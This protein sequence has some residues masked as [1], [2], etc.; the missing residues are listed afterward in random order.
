MYLLISKKLEDFD[1]DCKRFKELLLR[2]RD[3]DDNGY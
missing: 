1:F 2:Q 3:W